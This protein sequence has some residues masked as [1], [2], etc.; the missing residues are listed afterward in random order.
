MPAMGRPAP[1]GMATIGGICTIECDDICAM[2][3]PGT[4]SIEVAGIRPTL[5][6]AT[7]KFG[8]VCI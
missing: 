2:E 1:G 8:S 3:L 4:C 5:V 6:W 7:F